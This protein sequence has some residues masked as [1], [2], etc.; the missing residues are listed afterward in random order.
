MCH[1]YPVTAPRSN[2]C[3]LCSS[4][5]EME[6]WM[7]GKDEALDW[8]FFFNY[9]SSLSPHRSVKD[10]ESQLRSRF[11]KIIPCD[12]TMDNPL[13]SPAH[14]LVT[15]QRVS[16]FREAMETRSEGGWGEE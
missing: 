8:S 16:W 6:A 14:R 4:R 5:R 9:L 7:E 13:T 15:R 1:V 10:I 12:L 11:T 2:P 3:L